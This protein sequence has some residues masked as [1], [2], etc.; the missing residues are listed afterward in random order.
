[1]DWAGWRPSANSSSIFA[2]NAGRSSGLRLVTRPLSVTTSSSTQVAPALR[3]SVRRLGQDV[4]VRPRTTSASTSV[5]GAW[6]IA[7]TGLPAAKNALTNATASGDVRSW[8]G[9]ATPPGSS[10]AS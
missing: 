6:Q 10:S 3:R 2:Q 5:H 1:M 4:S 8:S 7:A 9:L